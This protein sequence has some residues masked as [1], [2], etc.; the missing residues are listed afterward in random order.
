[1][2]GARTW[3]LIASEL[4]THNSCQQQWVKYL[5]ASVN[6]MPFTD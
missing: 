3:R 5:D 4:R 6:T 1:M 2:Q